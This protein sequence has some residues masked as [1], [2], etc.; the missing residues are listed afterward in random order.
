MN[1]VTAHC[2]DLCN[3]TVSASSPDVHDKVNRQSDGFS[4]T[5]VRQSHVCGQHTVRQTCERLFSG[6]RV[7]RTEAAEVPGVQRLQQVERFCATDLTDQNAI[8]S[9]PQCRTKQV[10]NRDGRQRR[11]L[12]ER[13]LCTPRLEPNHVRFVQMNLCGLLDQNN[14]I[15]IGNVR[16]ERVEQ[17]GLAG[18]GTAGDQDVL[19]SCNGAGQFSRGCSSQRGDRNK[20]VEAVA[21]CE[22]PDGQDRTRNSAG[23][24]HRRYT[25]AVLESC[26]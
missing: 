17:R 8:R 25:G 19:L 23:R 24:E 11:L 21:A 26:I 15:A 6:I 20:V 22:L 10:G 14:A 3:A 9:M 18:T 12:A 7:D 5:P 2:R 1:V 16:S 4:D 13:Q